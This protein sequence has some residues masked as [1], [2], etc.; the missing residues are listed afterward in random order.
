MLPYLP[1]LVLL[2]AVLE[3]IGISVYVRETLKG[4]V[5]PNRVTW[6]MWAV[7]GFIGGAAALAEGVTWATIPVFAASVG[8]LIVFAASYVNKASYWRLGA[9]D[10]GSGLLSLVALILWGVTSDPNIAIMCAIV[11]DSFAAIPTYVKAWR[12]P[13]TENA[14]PFILGVLNPATSFAAI[15]VWT[16]SAYAF[17]LYLVM[18]NATL[19]LIIY[20]RKR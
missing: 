18:L 6:L 4:H 16:F 12:Q 2:G 7:P 19:A 13:K 9:F 17:P 5:K 20:F 10:Y 15:A 3:L 8:P 14:M 11:S 1:Q